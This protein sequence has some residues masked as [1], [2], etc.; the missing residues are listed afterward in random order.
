MSAHLKSCQIHHIIL[1]T[2]SRYN[3][4]VLASHADRRWVEIR[5][6]FFREIQALTL[7]CVHYPCVNW[8]LFFQLPRSFK[9]QYRIFFPATGKFTL[10]E[11]YPDIDKIGET[12]LSL[13]SSKPQEGSAIPLYHKLTIAGAAWFNPRVSIF[14]TLAWFPAGLLLVHLPAPRIQQWGHLGPPLSQSAKTSV[15]RFTWDKL[16]LQATIYFFRG[17]NISVTA[18]KKCWIEQG[19][20]FVEWR[21]KWNAD[22][23]FEVLNISILPQIWLWS[24][25]WRASLLIFIT[26]ITI[27]LFLTRRERVK[28][29]VKEQRHPSRDDIIM[30]WNVFDRYFSNYGN[31]QRFA[32][33]IW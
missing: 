22:N 24:N 1:V 27:F 31:Q 20:F 10:L 30:H 17:L 25:K 4:E 26:L 12:H 29:K 32:L 2:E 16:C 11:K 9:W 15:S 8:L 19:G 18:F 3:R 21:G 23:S 33:Y 7:W 14:C 5:H 13:G 6:Q 28:K